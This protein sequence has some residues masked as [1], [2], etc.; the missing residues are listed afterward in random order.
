MGRLGCRCVSDECVG[1]AF[2]EVMLPCAEGDDAA[3]RV[4]RR[5]TDG[6]AIAGN[7]LDAE[8]PHPAAQLCENFVPGVALDAIQ[9]PRNGRRRPF[10][11]YL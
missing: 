6:H 1:V 8:A 10:P 3:D 4:V 9:A 5:D 2:N 7:H 11:A